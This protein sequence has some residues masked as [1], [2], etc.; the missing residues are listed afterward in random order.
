MASLMII[1]IL[2]PF[3]G[4]LVLYFGKLKNRNV[5]NIIAF[6]ISAVVF[7]LSTTICFTNSL[8][9]E[10]FQ[11]AKDITVLLKADIISKFFAVIISCVFTIISVFSYKYLTIEENEKKFHSFYLLTLTMLM[12]LCYAGNLTTMYLAFELVTLCSMPLVMHSRT[13]ESIK[14]ALKYLYYSLG[15]AFVGLIG[16]FFMVYFSTGSD[17]FVLGGFLDTVKVQDYG[18]LMQVVIFITLIGFGV[19][20]GVF[21]FQGWLPTAHP[22]APSPAS[23]VLSGI[24]TKAG[25]IAIIR[26]VY[27]SIGSAF[28][29]D[30]WVQ[31]A[32]ISIILFTIFMG[33]SM[34]LIQKNFKKRL[35]YSTV[36]QVSYIVLGIAMLNEEAL[37]G[38]F[39]HIASHALIKVGLFLVAG[40][41]ILYTEK[42]EVD[43]LEGIGKQLP[44]TMIC[45]TV[46]SLGLIGIPPAGAF[47]SKW[48]L[49]IGS[50][51]SGLN[52]LDYLAPAVLLISAILTA[53]YLLP[54]AVRAFIV[55]DKSV[56]L[57]KKQESLYTTIP[58]VV[59]TILSTCVGLFADRI[60]E[61]VKNLV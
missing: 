28:I 44:V 31:Y 14:A 13:Q 60:V 39:L 20:T 58:L 2:L 4:A 23:A 15:G 16:I 29:K 38:S 57:E 50:I 17:E 47:V 19:K 3:I 25:V 43:E 9:I 54:I 55:K 45:Y 53:A 22:V 1:S 59:L 27:F 42:H 51:D 40:A 21:P 6:A 24:V 36:S 49:A 41:I 56:V 37:S 7:V 18:S 10:L 61:I 52:V 11:I 8:R 12:A 34:A 46:L 30:T 5:L 33:S 26:I 48:Y 35:A 32:W